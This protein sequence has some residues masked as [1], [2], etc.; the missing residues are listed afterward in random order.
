MKIDTLKALSPLDGRYSNVNTHLRDILSE[1]GLIKYRIRVEI[2]WF[3][4][5]SKQKSIP[6][7]P[8]LSIKDKI[9]LTDLIE[10]FSEKDAVEIKKIEKK[11]NHDVKAVEYYLKEKFSQ[12]A[13]LAKYLEFIH[14]ACTSEDINNLA[15]SLMIR[16]SSN[17]LLKNNVINIERQLRKKARSYANVSM[18]S[19]THGQ[20]AT[21]TTMGKELANTLS[22]LKKI[23]ESIESIKLSG[24]INGAVGNYNAHLVAY[25]NADW[26]QIS[27]KFILSLGLTWNPYTTQVEPKDDIAE[28]FLNYV[29]L[30]NVL[31]DFSRDV[32]GYISLGYFSQNLKKGEVGSSTMPHKV[33]PIDFE[34]AE[35]NLGISNA[36]LTHISSTVVISRWQ[37]DLS[38]STVM[39]NIS[40][41][42]GHT[43]VALKSL[44]KGIDKLQI[45][46]ITIKEDLDAS[47]EVLTEAI[48]TLLRKHLIPNGYELMKDLSRGKAVNKKDLMDFV[49]K[50]AITEEDKNILNQLSPS[51]Y[52]GLAKKLA[53]DI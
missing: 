52:I 38:D 37:R 32:W 39:R 2:E 9:Y 1:Y 48:Q 10:N 23:R 8:S 7:L 36:L 5:L 49:D 12:S 18:L 35:G 26:L 42:F 22:R 28:L 51:T 15:Y 43:T 25:P 30:N 21:P 3:I 11:T 40:G 31:I 27:N 13:K 14:F 41:C 44:E 33:N 17:Y 47:W 19:R 29:R 6:E 45:N 20:S 46:K 50:L 16:D 24:K 53:K 34:N 4:H